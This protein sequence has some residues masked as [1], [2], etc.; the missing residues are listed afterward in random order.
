MI[1]RR[2]PTILSAYIGMTDEL[3]YGTIDG[4]TEV[5]V[6]IRWGVCIGYPEITCVEIDNVLI[7]ENLHLGMASYTKSRWTRFLRRYFR[8]DFS[9]WLRNSMKKLLKYPS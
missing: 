7:D 9:I 3:A 4:D 6:P 5:A 8:E 2:Y 1:I